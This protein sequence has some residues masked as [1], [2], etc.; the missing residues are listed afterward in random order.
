[1]SLALNRLRKYFGDELLVSVGGRGMV[2]TPL[3]QSLIEPVAEVLLRLLS[4]S[5]TKVGSF[6]PATATRKFS[7]MASCYVID[8]LLEFV[9]AKLCKEA[10]EI[11]FEIHPLVWENRQ[12][13]RR[14]E[15]DMLIGP[16]IIIFPD[17][18]HESI[19]EDTNACIVW[20]KN[21]L[22]G[23]ELT[24]EQYLELGHVFSNLD[25]T[26]FEEYARGFG[27]MRKMEI[28]VPEMSTVPRAI[29]GTNR[30]ATIH[31]RHAQLYAKKFSLRLLKPPI[32]F[33]PVKE[34]I[35]WH[36]S[37][38]HDLGMAW[39]KSCLKAATASM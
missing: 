39:F 13:I 29:E 14:A 4:I 11:H 7:L 21:R 27:L 10:P 22:V 32:E 36:P 24:L 9:I 23:D 17:L 2:L 15:I 19:W 37:Q 18:P 31:T 35:Q 20:S 30:I 6:D 1:M 8:L 3:A 33:A 34:Y 38:D 26:C 12:K 16:E 5:D 25:I 28:Y